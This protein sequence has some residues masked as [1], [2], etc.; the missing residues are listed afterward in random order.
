MSTFRS[1]NFHFIKDFKCYFLARN[2]FLIQVDYHQ[3]KDKSNMVMKRL[4]ALHKKILVLTSAINEFGNICKKSNIVHPT[5]Q[6]LMSTSSRVTSLTCYTEIS[7]L[8]STKCSSP[9]FLPW[10]DEQIAKNVLLWGTGVNKAGK[11]LLRYPLC[12]AHF[13]YHN[14]RTGWYGLKANPKLFL[15]PLIF[16]LIDFF[17]LKITL[18]FLLSKYFPI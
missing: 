13:T 12:W 5:Q 9:P 10:T 18:A 2:L 3:K 8:A 6:S 11:Y 16:N 4:N 14:F 15:Q 7:L 1:Q 17:L